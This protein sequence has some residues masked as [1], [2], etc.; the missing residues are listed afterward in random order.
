MYVMPPAMQDINGHAPSA[1][2]PRESLDLSDQKDQQLLGPDG[3][4]VPSSGTAPKAATGS[5][6]AA[7]AAA[8]AAG[9]GLQDEQQQQ[10]KP[11][12]QEVRLT[13]AKRTQQLAEQNMQLPAADRRAMAASKRAS[14]ND[15]FRCA[16]CRGWIAGVTHA[17]V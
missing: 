4:K 8:A 13:G 6:T 10:A 16:H 2:V 9:L 1:A 17:A 3:L 11:L 14:G 15:H 7:A 5:L 12:I